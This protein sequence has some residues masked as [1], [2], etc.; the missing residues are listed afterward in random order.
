MMNAGMRLPLLHA[1]IGVAFFGTSRA[2][3]QHGSAIQSFPAGVQVGEVGAEKDLGEPVGLPVA[4][5]R[6]Q[7]RDVQSDQHGKTL[8]AQVIKQLP[9]RTDSLSHGLPTM[10][11]KGFPSAV[12]S[13][14][15]PSWK[16]SRS[17]TCGYTW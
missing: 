11:R 9:D 3:G 16:A 8:A 15:C 7:A 10:N 17:H 6:A 2:D 13:F 1:T 5:I 14:F 12:R 4:P